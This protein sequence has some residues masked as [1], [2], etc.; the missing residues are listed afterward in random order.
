MTG[1]TTFST[2]YL[3]N[4][5][6]LEAALVTPGPQDDIAYFANGNIT[7]LNFPTT[8]PLLTDFIQI[9]S[10]YINKLRIAKAQVVTPTKTRITTSSNYSFV[11]D[12]DMATLKS[13]LIYYE[14]TPYGFI[15]PGFSYTKITGSKGLDNNGLPINTEDFSGNGLPPT[16]TGGGSMQYLGLFDP[17]GTY[18]LSQAEPTPGQELGCTV[19]KIS[20][21]S[22]TLTPILPLTQLI[23]DTFGIA[24]SSTGITIQPVQQ[25]RFTMPTFR[26][27]T[28]FFIAI[29]TSDITPIELIDS[30][31]NS[32]NK[33]K[34][35]IFGQ[36]DTQAALLQTYTANTCTYADTAAA[37]AP[38]TELLITL[39]DVGDVTLTA[40]GN[41]L[42]EALGKF[43]T[44][45]TISITYSSFNVFD[46]ASS[47]PIETIE[48]DLGYG[49]TPF[50][51]SEYTPP[52]VPIAAYDAGGFML[53]SAAGTNAG[54]D[55][56]AG[57]YLI[58]YN[59]AS[60]L[61]VIQDSNQHISNALLP[62]GSIDTA[63]NLAIAGIDIPAP[64]TELEKFLLVSRVEGFGSA[65][66]DYGASSISPKYII[67]DGS[68][69]IPG[70]VYKIDGTDLIP[71]EVP[72]M[73]KVY[74]ARYNQNTLTQSNLYAIYVGTNSVTNAYGNPSTNRVKGYS[75]T[76]YEPSNSWVYIYDDFACVTHGTGNI[77]TGQ[78]YGNVVI[79]TETD[80]LTYIK[81]SSLANVVFKHR[82]GH[83]GFDETV[84]TLEGQYAQGKILAI[85]DS[86]NAD[87]VFSNQPNLGLTIGNS[88]SNSGDYYGISSLAKSTFNMGAGGFICI[89]WVVGNG[90]LLFSNIYQSYLVV[91][92]A[93]LFVDNIL[94]PQTVNYTPGANVLH[95]QGFTAGAITVTINGSAMI[96]NSILRLVFDENYP[97]VT[98]PDSPISQPVTAGSVA[99]FHVGYSG[100]ISRIK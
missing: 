50:Y 32:I 14:T 66:S 4:L 35:V 92:E 31:F 99:L 53:A 47:I 1:L 33:G 96:P 29:H 45:E 89:D 74:V 40:D 63:I 77:G 76:N 54:T 27:Y 90:G 6:L 59:G 55:I 67:G 13:Y 51:N 91:N 24:S 37:L 95:I 52:V 7:R 61:M 58:W 62:G 8:T 98:L 57:E 73:T 46:T 38:G 100:I 79:D 21:T 11:V 86:E 44:N 19:N 26:P 84:Q 97:S 36:I 12:M 78:P 48:F 39:N 20:D 34:R 42:F 69:P 18:N 94:T 17:T 15:I 75:L 5:Y 2:D 93:A 49:T 71:I 3:L 9:G 88:P 81:L 80:S 43:T 10:L 56:L 22:F 64:L 41:P 70:S 85:F 16:P 30:I 68:S 87:L 23:T 65:A 25:A 60:S 82:F 72:I 28:Y 83:T